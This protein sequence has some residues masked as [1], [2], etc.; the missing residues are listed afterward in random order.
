MII[1]NNLANF[2]SYLYHLFMGRLLIP[3]DY[4]ELTAIITI[5]GMLGM[6]PAAFGLVIIKF[7]SAARNSVEISSI[8]NWFFRCSAV[9]ALFISMILIIFVPLLSTFLNIPNTRLTFLLVPIF[10]LSTV[11]SFNRFYLQGLLRFGRVVVGV[12]S[13]L[14]VKLIVAILLVY[15]GLSVAGG[16]GGILAGSAVGLLLT[17][18]FLKAY[19][20]RKVN[21]PNV[22]AMCSYAIPVLFK[23]ISMTSLYSIDLVLVK[24]FF[25]SHEAGLYA[26]LSILG[27]IIFFASSPISSAMFPIVS[28]RQSEGLKYKNV[29]LLSLL[30]TC[31]IALPLLLIYWLFPETIIYLLYG[32][33]YLGGADLLVWF[34]V[35]MVI[36]TVCSLLGSFFLSIGKTRVTILFCLVSIIQIAGIWFIHKTLLEVLLVSLAASSLLLIL[37]L[38]YLHYGFFEQKRN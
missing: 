18:Y 36:F 16:L 14:I 13:E 10:L 9:F 15:G 4:G 28:K 8:I 17:C 7:I 2:G 32:A 34:G 35:F 5:L 1:G 19:F 6:I 24:H 30:L 37:L 20:K 33:K 12:L 3:A 29:F 27:K 25:T 23:S 21:T 11:A 22:G 26:A 31:L 38:L